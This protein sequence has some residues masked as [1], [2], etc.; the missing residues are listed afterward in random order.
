MPNEK[1]LAL[2]SLKEIDAMTISP[3][4]GSECTVLCHELLD[5]IEQLQGTTGIKRLRLLVRIRALRARMRELKCGPC[6]PD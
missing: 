3:A 6:L 5:D 2:P 4:S 1:E